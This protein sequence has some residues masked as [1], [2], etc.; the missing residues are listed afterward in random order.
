MRMHALPR[1]LPLHDVDIELG[2][3]RN[4]RAVQGIHC[5][6]RNV[7][8]MCQRKQCYSE[9]MSTVV[10]QHSGQADVRLT[11]NRI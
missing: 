10:W 1:G 9:Q 3:A 11:V 7:I 2:G 6:G 4:G 8:A 5:A